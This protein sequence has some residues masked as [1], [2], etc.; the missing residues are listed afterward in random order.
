M[1]EKTDFSVGIT[2]NPGTGFKPIPDLIAFDLC[3]AYP[4]PGDKILLHNTRNGKRTMVMIEVYRS[5]LLCDQ[6]QTL[7]RHVANIIETNPG[8]QG[9]QADIHKVLQGMLDKGMMV[10]AKN[11]CA[12]LKQK[13]EYTAVEPAAPVVVIITWERPEALERLLKSIVANCDTGQF[14]RLYVMDDSRRSDNIVQNQALTAKFAEQFKVT[15]QYFGQ[16]EQQSLLNGLAKRLPEHEDAIRFLADQSRWR[17]HWTSGL[18]RNLALLVSCGHRLVM[19]DDDT[20]CDVYMP[21]LAKPNISFS[22]DPREADFYA[23][24]NDWASQ[25]QPI[26]PDPINRHM[27]CLGLSFSEALTVLGQNNLQPAGFVNA[28]ALQISELQ[29]ESRVLI[30][31]C[32]SLGC[33]GT[34]SNT[35][36][37]DMAPVSLKRMLRSKKKTTHA[38]GSRKVWSGRNQP[39]FAPRPNM[40]QITG[41]DNREMLPPYLPIMRGEDRLFGCMLDFIFPTAVT[42]D[43]PWAIPHLPMPERGWRNKDL[44][45]TPAASFPVFPF[46]KILEYKSSCLSSSP[47]DR[48]SGLSAWFND[49]AAAAPES[50][51]AMYSDTRMQ[52]VSVQL[53]HLSSLLSSAESAPV[54]WQNYLRNGIRQLNTD[55]DL[56]SRGDFPVEG[57]P[58]SLQ[59]GELIA[60]WKDVWSGFADA[61]NAW[62]EIRRTAAEIIS[63]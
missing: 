37:P 20:V 19:I 12:S 10:S 34:N 44:D 18:T 47:V 17:D 31:E 28:T 40:S 59:G 29:P 42:L 48:L 13:H 62:P 3:K 52:S 2:V 23:N 9:Q 60:Y 43:Y 58:R 51:S 49:M 56:V 21:P 8:M 35:W 36:L 5:L 45:F 27:Q 32:G 38:L 54:D 26:N 11:V 39:H 6:F 24:E 61:L 7:D 1:N 55:L 4:V 16:V 50:L 53:Q 22:D 57:L 14:H 33:P 30:T 41:F 15:L 46:E 25:H 63:T